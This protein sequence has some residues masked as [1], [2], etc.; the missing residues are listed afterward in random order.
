MSATSSSLIGSPDQNKPNVIIG[1][2]QTPSRSGQESELQRLSDPVRLEK[3]S[4]M[5]IE[6]EKNS[7]SKKDSPGILELE[8]P[9]FNA[10]KA[11]KRLSGRARTPERMSESA[12]LM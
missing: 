7:G 2:L 1:L 3:S 6:E 10:E 5:V 4:A 9:S 12:D 11:G 8:S